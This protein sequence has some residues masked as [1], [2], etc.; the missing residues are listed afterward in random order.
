MN[1]NGEY[2]PVESNAPL[3]GLATTP[4]STRL[5]PVFSPRLMNCVIRDGVVRRRAGYQQLG[6]QLVGKVLVLT[7]FGEIND[8]PTLVVLTTHRQYAYNPATDEFT[9]LTPNKFTYAIVFAGVTSF[10]ITGDHTA[11]FTPGRLFPVTTGLN[12]GV[13]TVVTSAFGAGV[14]V[15]NTIEFP[16]F[17]GVVAGNI[18][19][20]DDFDTDDDASI[21]FEALTDING[22]RLV[23]TNGTDVPR[24]W[25]GSLSEDFE[26]W[27]PDYPDFITM[28]TIKVHNEH[29]FLG[30]ITTTSQVE[31]QIIAWSTA[32]DFETFVSGT[33]GAQLLYQLKTAI[34]AMRSLGDRLAIYSDDAIMTGVFVDVP[35]VFAFEMVIPEGVRLTSMNGFVSINVGHVILTD[36]NIYLFDGTRGLR[37]LGNEIRSDY[38][39]VKD[40]ERL[41]EICALNDYSKRTLYIAIPDV[42]GGVMVYTVEYDIFD[43]ANVSWA[44]ERYADD[45]TA[46]GFFVNRSE[47]LTWEDASWEPAGMLWSAELGTWAEQAE[48]MFFPIRAFGSSDGYVFICTEGVLTDDGIAVEQSYETKDFTVPEAFHSL[49]G[50]WGELEMELSGTSVDL[51]YS[52]DLG[53]NFTALETVSLTGSPVSYRIPFDDVSRTIRF[54]LVSQ[55][56]YELRWLRTWV[57]PNGPR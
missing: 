38:K 55:S 3:R 25:S 7:D 56:N 9:D 45:P 14:T 17:G 47:S 6:Q 11:D 41:H 32:G 34:K 20:A 54:R 40:Q 2:L 19:I 53:N 1:P 42:S 48:Q 21:D 12:K 27:Q 22:H 8:D 29:L 52:T 4:V 23:I 30:G 44:R 16:P 33:A 31:G 10:Q 51:S 15:I 49:L 46:W 39:K 5:D 35:A 18:V 37:I 24:V 28:R 43:L 13:Y 50:R 57:R 26:D 36:E